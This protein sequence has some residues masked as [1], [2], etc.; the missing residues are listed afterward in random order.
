MACFAAAC[1]QGGF[2]LDSDFVDDV[3]YT[4]DGSVGDG[5]GPRMSVGGRASRRA[6][7]LLE[8]SLEAAS[9]DSVDKVYDEFTATMR[10]VVLF[11]LGPPR[12]PLQAFESVEQHMSDLECALGALPASIVDGGGD[13]VVSHYSFGSDLQYQKHHTQFHFAIVADFQEQSEY[14]AYRHHR[15][16]QVFSTT[17]LEPVVAA[18]ASLQFELLPRGAPIRVRR[19]MLRH[20]VLFQWVDDVAAAKLDSVRAG[21]SLLPEE[22]PQC[23]NYFY[24]GDLGLTKVHTDEDFDFAI[25]AD[26]DNYKDYQIYATHPAHQE[27]TKRIL[28]PLIK[29]RAAVQFLL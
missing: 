21:L 6:S 10:H 26:F 8:S 28:R 7:A 25:I 27:F 16:H 29:N 2:C 24:G 5:A 20:V 22:I 23:V 14:W 15:A 13:Q 11:K 4:D 1:G 9:L 12:V 18:R 3:T 19:G 17:M